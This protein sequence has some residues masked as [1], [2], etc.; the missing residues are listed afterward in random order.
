[1]MRWLRSFQYNLTQGL[2]SIFRNSVMS[3]ASVLVLLSCMIILG[4]FYL[5]IANIEENFNRIDNL[6]VIEVRMP[7]TYSEDQIAE[8]GDALNRLC[9]QSDILEGEAVFVSSEEHL[10]RFQEQYQDQSWINFFNPTLNP[11]RPSY[12]LT[13]AN[14]SD[15]T[16]VVEVVTQIEGL[17]FSDGSTAVSITDINSPIDLYRNVTTVKR[18]LTAVG[19]W[20][21]GIL[22]LISLFVIMN[23]IKL[24]VFARRNEVMFM[25]YCGA[26]KAFIR[27]PFLVEGAILGLFSAGI[28]LGLEYLLY[29]Y[30]L[31]GVVTSMTTSITDSGIVLSPYLGHLPMLAVA[32]CALGLFAGLVSGSISLKKYLKV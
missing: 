10:H 27:T 2:K 4:T 1:M 29:R 25:R 20:M 19:L 12:M 8:I 28:A 9:A 31:S 18:T 22:L 6:N 24:G 5:V 17:K 16:E 15:I 14:F 21:I 13:F 32:F 26:T 30:V 23:T 11:L 3:T 7:S